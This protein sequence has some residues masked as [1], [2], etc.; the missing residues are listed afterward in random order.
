MEDKLRVLKE[1]TDLPKA[2]LVILLTVSV[3][4]TGY[5][6]IAGAW[7]SNMEARAANIE[8]R[9]DRFADA[10][11]RQNTKIDDNATRQNLK[12]DLLLEKASRIEGQNDVILKKLR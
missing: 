8:L 7:K 12:M 11:L 6:F 3:V 2:V 10:L 4:F 1:L 5:S 9:Q